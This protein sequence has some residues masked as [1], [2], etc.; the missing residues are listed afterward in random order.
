MRVAPA[1]S[2]SAIA[3]QGGAFRRGTEGHGAQAEFGHEKD[4]SG[5]LIVAHEA[6]SSARAAGTACGIRGGIGKV[7]AHVGQGEKDN[8][9][10]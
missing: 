6:I 2:R 5:Q 8:R 4:R 10:L 9:P 3:P 1:S 7:V